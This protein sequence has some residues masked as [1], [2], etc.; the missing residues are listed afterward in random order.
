MKSAVIAAVMLATVATAAAAPIPAGE[1][2]VIWGQGYFDYDNQTIEMLPG[3]S[4]PP[5][6]PPSFSGLLLGGNFNVT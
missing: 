5:Q 4:L 3:L 1:W 2:L 6:I